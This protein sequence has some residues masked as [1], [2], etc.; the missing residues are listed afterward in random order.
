MTTTVA[1]LAGL[2]FMGVQVAWSPS[3]DARVTGY[4]VVT[5]T[6]ASRVYDQNI[7]VG[8][9]LTCQIATQRSTFYF[10]SAYAYGYDSADTS[11]TNL[12]KSDYCNEVTWPE[13][14]PPAPTG[15][16]IK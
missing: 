5:G 14:P 16:S 9:N 8:T 15:F 10:I 6:T 13:P 7:D 4:T 1:L 11:L 2:L 3:P 12:L